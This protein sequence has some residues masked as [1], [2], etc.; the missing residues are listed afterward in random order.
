V[1]FKSSLDDV[2]ELIRK[3]KKIVAFTGAGISVESGIPDFRSANGLWSKFD[4]EIYASK[5]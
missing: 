4:P 2:A 3:S 1:H 5:K